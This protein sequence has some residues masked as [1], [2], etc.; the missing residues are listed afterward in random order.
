MSERAASSDRRAP[1]DR[2]EERGPF[3]VIGDVHGC[4][5]ELLE[6][7]ARLG[8]E[9]TSEGPAHPHRTAIFV[10]DLVDRGPASVA[11]LEL[12]L[13]MCARGAAL[14]VIGNHEAKLL[15][16]L[17]GRGRMTDM[18]AQT[19]RAF[20]AREPQEQERWSR[21]LAAWPSHLVLDGGALVVAHAGLPEALHRST[22]RQARAFALYGDVT[23]KLDAHGLPERLDWAA[24]Y[25][26]AAFVV[27]GHT[28][29]AK[30]QIRNET[31]CVD[32]G[33]VFGGALTAFRWPER[34]LVSVPAKRAYVAHPSFSG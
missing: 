33:C 10:G 8:Y 14:A 21:S 27:Y 28:P 13:G 26:G 7:L 12:A 19:L 11:C 16:L 29:T 2:R 34:E 30:A 6:L 3:D 25:R 15:R 5:E 24:G 23:G 18:T 1:F 4:L 32:T 31:L 17:E 9:P 20:R 22:S